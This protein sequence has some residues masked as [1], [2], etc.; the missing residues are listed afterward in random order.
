MKKGQGLSLT[1]IIIAAIGLIVLVVL[2]AIFTGQIGSWGQAISK[3]QKVTGCKDLKPPGTCRTNCSSAE[4][5]AYG[6]P[7]CL[8]TQYCCVK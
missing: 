6:I 7:G 5:T 4:Q 1:T 2:V 8:P 3:E